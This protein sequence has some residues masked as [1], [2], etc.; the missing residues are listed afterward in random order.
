M[1]KALMVKNNTC[2]VIGHELMH[3]FPPVGR[4]CTLE[5]DITLFI[6][7]ICLALNILIG[8]IIVFITV[9]R[10]GR[11]FILGEQ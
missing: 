11:V 8:Q 5:V 3:L 6:V 7:F 2:E 10:V 9:D 1:S 4:K